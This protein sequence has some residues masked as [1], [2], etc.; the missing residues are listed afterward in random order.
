MDIT[1]KETEG[2]YGESANKIN[3]FPTNSVLWINTQP[4]S[5][6][7]ALSL[8]YF[9]QLC[10]IITVR[11]PEHIFQWTAEIQQSCLLMFSIRDEISLSQPVKRLKGQINNNFFFNWLSEKSFQTLYSAA[12]GSEA[13]W[14]I[15]L[16]NCYVIGDNRGAALLQLRFLLR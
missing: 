1:N 4:N 3:V 13:I 14:W 6:H 8:K 10:S 12:F 16:A 15:C 9:Y 7:I 2:C 11:I 5:H